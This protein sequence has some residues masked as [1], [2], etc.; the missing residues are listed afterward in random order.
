MEAAVKLFAQKGYN[1]TS[2]QEIADSC[3]ISK[4]AFYLHFRSKEALMLSIFQ[5]Y[6]E[7]VQQKMAEIEHADLSSREKLVQQI[8]VHLQEV[9]A[10]KELFVLQFREQMLYLNQEMEEFFKELHVKKEKWH[11]TRFMTMY[12]EGVRPYM[13]DMSRLFD[14]M[15]NAY[16]KLM[17]RQS[18]QLDM[19]LLANFIVNRLDDI[20][21]GMLANHEK[22]ILTNEMYTSSVHQWD[23][24]KETVRQLLEEMEAAIHSMDPGFNNKKELLDMLNILVIEIKKNEPRAIIFKGMLGNF[25]NVE[26]LRPYTKKILELMESVH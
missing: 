12:G 1:T 22:P 20:V 16:L 3:G 8:E 6:S 10:R 21:T 7:N 24:L 14:G 13:L 23:T 15:L 9:L 2:V 11:A 4:G 19:N 5:F 17:I 18:V 25:N 26:K